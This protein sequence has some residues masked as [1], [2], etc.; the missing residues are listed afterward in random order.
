MELKLKKSSS[1]WVD[2]GK[3]KNDK[4]IRFLIDY[5]TIEQEEKLQYI[6]LKTV[7]E[8]EETNKILDFQRQLLKFAI[9]DWEGV[10]DTDGNEIKCKVVKGELDKELHWALF[11]DVQRTIDIGLIVNNEIE[12]T[13]LDKK[14]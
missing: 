1:K 2:I 12:F 3:G 14:K 10:T 7:P 8:G 9:K 13:A 5:P 6:L 11:K 4:P